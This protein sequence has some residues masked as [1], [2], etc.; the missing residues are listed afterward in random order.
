MVTVS[1]APLGY[2][3]NNLPLN[4]AIYYQIVATNIYGAFLSVARQLGLFSIHQ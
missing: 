4:Q 3:L 1:S 2:T